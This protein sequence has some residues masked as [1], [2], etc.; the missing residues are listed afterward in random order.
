MSYS[1]R[2]RSAHVGDGRILHAALKCC[3][4]GNVLLS[5]HAN[6][7]PPNSLK[8]SNANPKVETTEEKGTWV[9]SLVHSILG[10]KGACQSFGMGIK[11]NDKW[12]NYSYGHA[13]IK[14]QVG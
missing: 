12:V 13:P 11:T 3:W 4:K 6:D 7:T 14:Q 8:Y 5:I 1:N 9:C 2:G 10:V